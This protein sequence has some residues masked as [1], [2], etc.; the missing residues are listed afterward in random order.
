MKTAREFPTRWVFPVLIT[1]CL[2]GVPARAQYGGGRGEPNDPYLIYTAEQ[3]NAIGAEPNDWDKHFKLMAD[4]DLAG[5][6]DVPFNIIGVAWPI[7]FT[8][9][10]D[11]NDHT[12][13]NFT[14]NSAGTAHVGLFGHVG[15]PCG[16][17][18]FLCAADLAVG[19]VTVAHPADDPAPVIK[20]VRLVDPVVDGNDSGCV[21]ALAGSLGRGTITHCAVVNGIV[22]G[23][24]SVGGLVGVSSGVITDCFATDGTVSGAR[25][26]VGGLVGS[27]DGS[28]AGS[29]TTGIVTGEGP[30]G[31]LVGHCYGAI[32][33]CYST[34]DVSGSY[35]LGGLVGCNTG[36]IDG[37]YAGG[38]VAGNGSVGGLVGAQW[39]SGVVTDC[40][41]TGSARGDDWAGGLLG[42][43]RGS[44]T[45]CY[46][47]GE[48]SPAWG[49]GGLVGGEYYRSDSV[50][51]CFWDVRA[52]GQSTSQGGT[53]L[54]TL[55]MQW[56]YT[57]LEAGWDWVGEGENGTA[58]TWHLPPGGGYPVLTALTGY[59][60]APLQGSGTPASPY[61]ISSVT[62]LEAIVNYSPFLHYRLAASLDLSGRRWTGPLIGRFAGTFDGN[63]QTLSH[64]T[65]E[66]GSYAGLFGRLEPG[67]AVRDLRLVDVNV[68]GSDEYA[69]ALV[70]HNQ[71][72]LT[73][74][75]TS[76]VVSG[77]SYCGGMVGW[78]EDGIVAACHSD[79]AVDGAYAVGGLVGHNSGGS[80]AGCYSAGPVSGNWYVGGLLGENS[81]WVTGC[82]WDIE[83][84]GQAT[85]AGGAALTTGQM[86]T[87]E[88]FLAAGWDFL[89]EA[90]NGTSEIWQMAPGG[91]GPVLAIFRDYTR[92][93]LQGSGTA[94]SPYLIFGAQELGALIHYCPRACYRLAGSVDLSGSRWI[95]AVVPGFGG[96]FD[97]DGL[98]ISH[99]T[100]EGGAHLGLFGRLEAGGQIRDLG[101]VDVNVAG[102][103]DCIGALAGSSS[104]ADVVGCHSSGIVSGG[105]RVGG[106]IGHN[107][108]AALTDSDSACVVGGDVGV[109]GLLGRSEWSSVT[110]CCSTG[111]VA[112]SERVGGLVG[113]NTG[114]S[115]TACY[116]T[117]AVDARQRAGGLVGNN[118]YG[119]V[120]A[121]YSTGFVSA[122]T[123][124]GGL[125]GN[126][127]HG[128]LTACFWDTDT[129]GQ[130]T[131]AG[132]TAKTTAEMHTAAI[133]LEAGWDF[134]DET[135]NGTDEI[136]WIL[137]KQ[138][139]PQL[140]WELT[141]EE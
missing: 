69:G 86:Q 99:L 126:D 112:G 30:T 80:V 134:I 51:G 2:L 29:Y 133:F 116:S 5:L 6:G 3:M 58:Q 9:V 125:I 14:C 16:P 27:A 12:I 113:W 81:G 42:E 124:V 41:A 119:A 18:R 102:S 8:G 111:P 91:C 39:G 83:A 128:I 64:L 87:P 98:A 1:I 62:E 50:T 38:D 103:G 131:S 97:G 37:C 108:S 90:S 65:I 141:G 101:V 19:Q 78:N 22:S 138:D 76:G 71:G 59:T 75:Y 85:S 73:C 33:R 110:A 107:W 45:H 34:A 74:C 63:A 82:F 21:G 56:A 122:G 94:E 92:P 36:T 4:V 117:G 40:Y 79:S 61:L 54:A 31:G 17:R 55:E 105:Q 89:D 84:S 118:Y 120:T 35:D 10:F 130:A 7:S 106:L 104:Y 48:V 77:S 137:P 66:G 121:C 96:T 32:T 26:Y 11:G 57:Y 15:T 13:S 139:Y 129:S 70:G 109:G 123:Y 60:L 115:L 135:A 100:V 28:I 88:T 46:A 25:Y 43:N 20:N 52:S 127:L 68:I 24:D 67:A 95:T 72:T 114:G 93:E 132:G 49:A 44:V 53:G 136:W 23:G 140:W 47:T